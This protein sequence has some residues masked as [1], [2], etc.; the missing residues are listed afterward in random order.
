MP[1]V[2]DGCH[3]LGVGGASLPKGLQSWQ[4]C[5]EHGMGGPYLEKERSEPGIGAVRLIQVLAE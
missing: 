1:G 3:E 5:C 4:R 2:W